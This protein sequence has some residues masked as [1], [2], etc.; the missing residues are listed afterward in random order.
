MADAV[1]WVDSMWT[2]NFPALIDNSDNIDINLWKEFEL[3]VQEANLKKNEADTYKWV[4]EADSML[5]V[6]SCFDLLYDS[7]NT[8]P[9]SYKVVKDISS[10]WDIKALSNL[11]LFGWRLLLDRLSTK[12]KLSLRGILTNIRDLCCAFC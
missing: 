9:L 2:W 7:N 11:S 5:K 10:L 4:K 8:R 3:T 1:S 6:I 12:E